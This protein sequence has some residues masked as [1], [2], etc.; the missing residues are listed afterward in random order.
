MILA[1]IR[2]LGLVLVVAV[3]HPLGAQPRGGVLRGKIINGTTGAPGRAER[4]AL[5]KMASGLEPVASASDVS[6]SFTL[7]NITLAGEVPYLLQVTSG[8]VNYNQTISFG[9]GY[10]AEASV[11]V[12]EPTTD[13]KDVGIE[14]A[15]FLLRR[16]HDKLRI[17]K[18]FIVENKTEP[19]KTL[20]HPQ[21]TFRFSLPSDMVE[22]LTVSASSSGGMPVPQPSEALPDG[23]GYIARTALKPG[24]T[25]I[26]I[27]Y[28]VDY[29]K[30]SYHFHEKAHYPLPEVLALV[31]PADIR[32]EATGLESMGTEPKGRFQ[33]VG[34]SNLAA[35]DPIDF[36]LAGGSDH[37]PELGNTEDQQENA[38]SGQVMVLP[39][40]T[41]PIKWILV[42]LMAA[43]LGYGLLSSLMPA[44]QQSARAPASKKGSRTGKSKRRG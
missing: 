38:T 28:E 27:S 39:D 22:L 2:F 25:E 30:Q 36:H 4:V 5:I 8:G 10:E 40:A 18:L 13:W 41:L 33:I 24:T 14:T 15:R 19:K 42:V 1:W 37:A 26:A 16:Q 9:R 29:S 20:F 43:A 23:S 7:E 44:E 17:D 12:Y 31:S 3:A 32:I 35:G 11:T 21:G 6:S 34:A